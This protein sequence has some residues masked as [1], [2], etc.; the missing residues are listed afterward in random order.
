[1]A[2]LLNPPLPGGG[3]NANPTSLGNPL[4]TYSVTPV[5]GDQEDIKSLTHFKDAALRYLGDV[6][7][8]EGLQAFPDYPERWKFLLKKWVQPTSRAN[9][10]LDRPDYKTPEKFLDSLISRKQA[11]SD[12]FSD[13]LRT[14]LCALSKPHSMDRH[15]KIIREFAED[16]FDKFLYQNLLIRVTA[17]FDI[18]FAPLLV[19]PQWKNALNAPF[20]LAK[21]SSIRNSIK[22][23]KDEFITLLHRHFMMTMV[24][25]DTKLYAHL[26]STQ[27]PLTADPSDFTD[28][29]Q[30]KIL[31][32]ENNSIYLTLFAT[33][34]L[35]KKLPA[36][37]GG[38][39]GGN[40][41]NRPP[42]NANTGGAGGGTSSGKTGAKTSSGGSGS[43]GGNKSQKTGVNA[44]PQQ[45]QK[46]NVARN[47]NYCKVKWPKSESY[48]K[49]DDAYCFRNPQS[50]KYDAAKAAI[51]PTK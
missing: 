28:W 34:P 35:V 24:S 5:F 40:I 36:S 25:A 8:N 30:T 27:M 49:H 44:T 51:P 14:F 1:M 10:L 46:P 2:N 32:P 18:D 43:S 13:D 29:I 20:E 19:N 7:R 11:K 23:F 12:K 50:P 4:V 3:G 15:A 48:K 41:T 16:F 42:S 22:H 26:E 39:S 6:A 38:S 21:T 9:D 37:A 17:E 47:C 45:Q 33:S 31:D